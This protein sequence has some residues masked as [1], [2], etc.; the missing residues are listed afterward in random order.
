MHPAIIILMTLY[1]CS[2]RQECP[3]VNWRIVSDNDACNELLASVAAPRPV[4]RNLPLFYKDNLNY[5]GRIESGNLSDIKADKTD[6]I[7]VLKDIFRDEGVPHNLV[8]LAEVESSFNPNARSK[9]GAVGLFQLMPTTA[10]RFGLQLFPVDDRKT[11]DKSAR[12][13]ACYL[14][15]LYAEFGGWA[16]A[17]AAYNG[18]EGMVSRTMKSHNARTFSEV[19]PYLPSET[20]KYVPRVMAKMALREDQS[21][22]VFSAACFPA[23]SLTARFP[24]MYRAEMPD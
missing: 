6:L 2:P 7:S 13:A 22:G 19:A 3:S 15:R 10:E 23:G 8:W 24:I 4:S 5:S 21:R 17:L 16:L 18:G 12:A 14:R 1:M 11:P 9:A 20:R